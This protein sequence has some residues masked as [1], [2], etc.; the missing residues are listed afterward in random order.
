MG[1]DAGPSETSGFGPT[2]SGVPDVGIMINRSTPVQIVTTVLTK[3]L[4]WSVLY[5]ILTW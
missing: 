4:A 3:Q 1:T 2:N 5:E